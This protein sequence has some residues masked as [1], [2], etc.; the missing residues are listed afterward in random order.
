[1]Y[2]ERLSRSGIESSIYYVPN[3]IFNTSSPNS[4]VQMPNCT[5]Y[6]YC[7]GFESTEATEPFPI[8]RKTL[9]FG[10]AQLW[11]SN[12]PLEKGSELRTGSIGVFDG[13]FGHVCMVERKIDDTHALITESQYD[14]DKSLR[15]YKYWQKREVELIVGKATLSGVGKLLGFLYL[16]IKDIRTTL[17]GSEQVS[18]IEDFVNV[19]REPEGDLTQIG[20]FAPKGIYNV[21]ESQY[22]NG[23]YWYKL[24]KNSWVREGEWL[25]YHSN[26]NELELDKLRVENEVLKKKLKEIQEICCR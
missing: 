22:L 11:Y 18:I 25:I 24:D 15:N 21:L 10:N 9:G 8:A 6:A 2:L 4:S 7:R 26:N 13:S 3:G 20:C 17:N 19:R 23:Y 1:M 5:M 14:D 12:S 16:P